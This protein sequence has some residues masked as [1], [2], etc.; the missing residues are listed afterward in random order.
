MTI[1]LDAE[2]DKLKQRLLALSALVE[3]SL[4]KA[5]DG[6]LETNQALA[7]YVIDRDNE[8]DRLEVEVE[9]DCLKILALHQPVANDL[10]FIV[11]VLKMNN[12]LERIGDLA[13]NIAQRT[14]S[15]VKLDESP[16]FAKNIEQMTTGARKMLK[17]SLEALIKVDEELAKGV[18]EADNE[19]DDLNRNT[20]RLAM[21]KIETE[22]TSLNRVL[23]SLSVSRNLERIADLATN[24]A[25]DVIYMISGEIVR[26]RHHILE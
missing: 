23:L 3:E 1:H 19:V 2:I 11:A 21:E 4:H 17:Q 15:L 20:Y 8:I 14:K 22:P 12:D 7:D 9:E 25:E 24:I 16:L 5:V 18:R 26:H 10:R 6:Y 13:T